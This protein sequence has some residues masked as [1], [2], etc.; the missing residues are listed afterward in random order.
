M[1]EEDEEATWYKTAEAEDCDEV[2]PGEALEE[3]SEEEP[4]EAPTKSQ[5]EIDK[6]FSTIPSSW[7]PRALLRKLCRCRGLSEARG[8]GQQRAARLLGGGRRGGRPPKGG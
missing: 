2:E 7:Q 5:E 6:F 8:K 1:E 3:G 4:L